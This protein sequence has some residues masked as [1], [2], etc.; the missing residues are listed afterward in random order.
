[1]DIGHSMCLSLPFA[2]AQRR[3]SSLHFYGK[4]VYHPNLL[5]MAIGRGGERQ[6]IIRSPRLAINWG[7]LPPL[8]IH[9]L[10]SDTSNHLH[11]VDAA[12]A[13]RHSKS[14]QA[15]FVSVLP[16]ASFFLGFD[17][18]VPLIGIVYYLS[19]P[20]QHRCLRQ[21]ATHASPC[22]MGS[23]HRQVR[24]SLFPVK[25]SPT[26]TLKLSGGTPWALCAYWQQ[27]A[28]NVGTCTR[29]ADANKC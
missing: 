4:I 9:N 15:H 1:M 5:S 13:L 6:G 20:K 16:T 29:C 7:D 12:G 3:R 22:P 8:S 25:R 23:A 19:N 18:A 28:G 11:H 17:C 24:L 26:V 14:Y 10:D 21:T 2:M 27:G